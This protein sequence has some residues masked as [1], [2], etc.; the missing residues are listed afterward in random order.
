LQV[1]RFAESCRA[2]TI[3]S[4]FPTVTVFLSM[5]FPSSA[6]FSAFFLA[7]FPN[8]HCV[9]S[10]WHSLQL[11]TPKELGYA[12]PFFAHFFPLL[13][14]PPLPLCIFL[15]SRPSRQLSFLVFQCY[16]RD[17]DF[18]PVAPRTGVLRQASFVAVLK[19]NTQR[20]PLCVFWGFFD[21]WAW[22]SCSFFDFGSTLMLATECGAVWLLSSPPFHSDREF[23]GSDLSLSF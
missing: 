22:E 16:L 21:L 7:L 4:Y 19:Q 23:F 8:F 12:S 5:G 6:F 1:L 9:F 14:S 3:L 2:S 18:T 15:L 17:V 20:T 13:Q 11:E 10:F